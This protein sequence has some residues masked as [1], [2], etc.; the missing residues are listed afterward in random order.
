MFPIFCTQLFIISLIEV[1]R[2]TY[3]FFS[4]I[5]NT[6]SSALQSFLNQVTSIWH[7]EYFH[8]L[9]IGLLLQ[10]LVL[11]NLQYRQNKYTKNDCQD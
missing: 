2:S 8:L 6:F 5:Y 3:E 10:I 7:N 9:I 4:E 11:V 1:D